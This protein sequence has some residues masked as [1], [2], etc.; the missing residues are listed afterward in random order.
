MLM[1]II[2]LRLDV[3]CGSTGWTGDLSMEQFGCWIKLLQSAKVGGE[4][5]KIPASRFT[6]GWLRRNETTREVWDAMI[7]AGV[8]DGAIVVTDG[9]IKITNWPKYQ[10]DPNNAERVE[11]YR[12][13]KKA[14]AR[15]ARSPCQHACN[16]DVTGRDVTGQKNT[17]ARDRFVG[18]TRPGLV[19]PNTPEQNDAIGNA[20]GHV[21]NVV[22][23]FDKGR[24]TEITN[25][26]REGGEL[27]DIMD[28]T[29]GD[30]N[31]ADKQRGTGRLFF[32]GLMEAR[33]L[34]LK[35]VSRTRSPE[36]PPRE[37]DPRLVAQEERLAKLLP[38]LTTRKRENL[39]GQIVAGLLTEQQAVD[40]ESKT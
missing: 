20:I 35:Q 21:T 9:E 11:R 40:Q 25:F 30:V 13:K 3:D 26:I 19:E 17:D 12:E 28:L 6:E 32:S 37:R 22:G 2:W 38:D 34:R 14:A 39:A 24:N 27:A 31:E 29:E 15:A 36:V 7:Q 10:Q 33:R 16:D 1:A 18:I 8:E 4:K 23:V 5:G